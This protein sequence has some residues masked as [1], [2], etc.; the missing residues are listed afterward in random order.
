[1]IAARVNIHR[2]IYLASLAGIAFSLPLSV[3]TCS[4]FQFLLFL[5]YLFEG[6]YHLK[7]ERIRGNRAFL[8]FTLFYLLHLLGGLWSTDLAY[9]LKDLWIKIPLLVIPLVVSSSGTI[10]RREQRYILLAFVGGVFVSSLASAGAMAGLYATDLNGFRS[11]SLFIS[12]IRFSLMIVLAIFLAAWILIDDANNLPRSWKLFYGLCLLWFPVFLLM[13]KALTGIVIAL[14][15]A[16]FFGFRFALRLRDQ[17]YR[18]MLTAIIFLIPLLSLLYLSSAI[19]TYFTK[20]EIVEEEIDRYTR[21]GNPY[22]NHPRSTVTENGHY[23]WMYVCDLELDSAWNSVSEID[24]RGE[25]LNG[26]PLRSTLI[27]FLASKNL[28]K[29]A[30]GLSQLSAD[31]IRAI[32]HGTANC[33]Y[34]KRL[35]LYSRLYELIW[36]I[37]HYRN[38][39]SPNEKSI[40]QRYYYLR[41]GCH[42][43][44]EHWLTGVGNGDVQAAFEAHYERVG[45]PLSQKWRR[46]AHNQYLTLFISFGVFGFIIC[47][48]ALLLPVSFS[49]RG[50]QVQV[51]AF[52]LIFLLSMLNEDTLE[53]SVGAAFIAFFYAFFLLLPR[54][55]EDTA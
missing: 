38:G 23:V 42:I 28:R 37:D 13:L 33:L 46:R 41:A 25:T 19:K 35:S 12:H 24:F 31:E 39:S 43:A 14:A 32:E 21:L 3:F 55:S 22:T 2:W 44:R 50:R 30:Y 20:D 17:V 34:M 8:I 47:M 51:M 11:Y 54:E 16:L 15:V 48:G 10:G 9:W 4:L 45:S 26:N 1:M 29:D 5:N 27:R 7:W 49:G 52:M 36:E 40:V 53:T 6:Q 18:Y